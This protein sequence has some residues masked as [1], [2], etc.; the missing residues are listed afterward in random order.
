MLG[1][2]VTIT[3]AAANFESI[4]TMHNVIRNVSTESASDTQDQ[5]LRF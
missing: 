2:D 4:E 5:S 1:D 3:L